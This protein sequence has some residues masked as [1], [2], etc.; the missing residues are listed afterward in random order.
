MQKTHSSTIY[1]SLSERGFTILEVLVA[2]VVLAA[3]ILPILGVQSAA[4]E[5]VIRNEQ[6]QKAVLIARQ[7]LSFIE[8][9]EQVLGTSRAEKSAL[10]LLQELASGAKGVEY[11]PVN[12]VQLRQFNALFVVEP[13]SIEMLGDT[14]LLR[15]VLEISWS[16]APRDRIQ[17]AYLVPP[18]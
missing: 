18:S 14:T 9:S 4:L 11:D 6:E 13:W 12:K 7:V 15:V 8:G 3:A 2:V 17:I 16:E 10:E 5:R 1:T